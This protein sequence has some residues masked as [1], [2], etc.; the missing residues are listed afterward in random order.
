MTTIE[1]SLRVK[2]TTKSYQP[3]PQSLANL[4]PYPKGVSGNTGSGNGYSLT[5]ALKNNIG[6]PLKKPRDDAPA[7]DHIVYATLL[8]AINCEPSS[9]H[10]REVWNRVDGIV[11]NEKPQYTDNRQYNIIIQGEQSREKFQQLLSGNPPGQL[12]PMEVID[13]N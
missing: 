9:A 4:K 7:R 13:D 12:R 2:R 10:L 6:K 3:P 5:A 8:G 11:E 1:K